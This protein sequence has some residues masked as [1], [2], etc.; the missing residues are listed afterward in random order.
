MEK[1]TTTYRE[2]ISLLN[3]RQRA[4][5]RTKRHKG[6]IVGVL[7][8]VV[9]L[10][11]VGCK[12][13]VISPNLGE[14][15]SEAAMVPASSR[16]PVVVIPGILGS[17]L[18]QDRTRTVV[19]G[20][21]D[22]GY[23]NPKTDE[24]ARL[25]ALPMTRPGTDDDARTL[26]LST[27]TDDVYPAGVLDKVKIRF[28]GLP[29]EAE[30]YFHILG[31]LG[32]G[33]YRDQ[34]LGDSGAI[35]Y[36]TT[37]YSCFQYA[38]D[39]RRDNAES[40]AGLYDYL[41][42]LREV[43]AGQIEAETGQRPETVKFDLVAHSMGGLVT[44]YMLRYGDAPL[45]EDGSLP[46]L[47][48]KGADLVDRVIL[49]GTPNGGSIYSFREL[50]RGQT[51]VP[52]IG[53]TYSA[54][55]LGTMPSLYQLMPRPEQGICRTADGTYEGVY[56]PKV[57]AARGWGLSDPSSAGVAERRKLMPDVADDATRLAIA[58]AYQARCL[59]RAQ[60]F[61][62]ALDLTARP[63]EDVDLF[64][65]AGDA[66]PTPTAAIVDEDHRITLVDDKPGDGTVARYSALMDQRFGAEFTRGLVSPIRWRGVYFMATDHLGITKD[67]AFTDNMLYLLLEDPR[68]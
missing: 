67:P 33:G 20:A 66:L 61:H 10:T 43:V 32:V 44:R 50:V 58:Q 2:I 55:I 64:L 9:V 62:Q 7:L 28:L 19:W 25:M 51:V 29:V 49:V 46:E 56:D 31:T 12:S 47:T 15:Y 3:V 30:A 17:R 35:N 53:P 59:A 5:G 22:R 60:Q 21:F 52:L 41:T 14:I 37:H 36:G 8:S 68:D 38:Y 40:A 42:E 54:Q 11:V 26:A 1:S 23:A 4:G 27:F 48:W 16:N 57:W 65:F 63:P 34:Q 45:P 24:G 39:W 13:S 18:E 6:P